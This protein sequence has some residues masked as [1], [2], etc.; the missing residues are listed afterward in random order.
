MIVLDFALCKHSF[1]IKDIHKPKQRDT[2]R[3]TVFLYLT[4]Q[5]GSTFFSQ[6]PMLNHV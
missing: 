3:A 1:T 2:I 4:K 6:F 5:E